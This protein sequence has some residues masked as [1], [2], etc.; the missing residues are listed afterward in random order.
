MRRLILLAIG[1]FLLLWTAGA[2]TRA[3]AAVDSARISGVDASLLVGAPQP[4]VDPDARWRTEPHPIS[5]AGE[6]TWK[7]SHI[8]AVLAAAPTPRLF[9]R[10]RTTS[11]AD[12]PPPAVPHDL[13]HIPLL[14]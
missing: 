13:R 8:H 7:S 10:T 14:I 4:P 2:K 5:A 9:D 11:S 3:V 1:V 6:S 12:L